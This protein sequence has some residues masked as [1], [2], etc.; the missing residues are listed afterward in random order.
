MYIYYYTMMKN[1]MQCNKK[2]MM[3]SVKKVVKKGQI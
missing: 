2:I 1:V 3:H